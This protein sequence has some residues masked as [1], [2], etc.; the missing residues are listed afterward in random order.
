M[1]VLI[2]SFATAACH[3]SYLPVAGHRSVVTPAQ[4]I[5]AANVA[6]VML[7]VALMIGVRAFVVVVCAQFVNLIAHV[8]PSFLVGVLVMLA[9][10]M[11]RLEILV[12]TRGG[13]LF[14]ACIA[15]AFITLVTLAVIVSTISIITL[16]T[17]QPNRFM[18]VCKM[19]NLQA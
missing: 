15:T 10:Y 4:L 19:T 1:E 14:V 18:M 2:D 12:V 3:A 5:G 7:V 6:R 8:C 9:V 16:H 13:T 11:A 17:A